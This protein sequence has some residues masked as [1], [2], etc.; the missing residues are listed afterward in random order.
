MAPLLPDLGR[1]QG[2]R[3]QVG[4]RNGAAGKKALALGQVALPALHIEH[5]VGQVLAASAPDLEVI[6][7]ASRHSEHIGDVD[8]VN[9]VTYLVQAP[10]E[11]GDLVH[12]CSLGDAAWDN[13]T[14]VGHLPA[15]Q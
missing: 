10:Q 4:G 9:E 5:A 12:S 13:P 7:V 15:E 3:L 1:V 8:G 2:G 6:A 14:V 11:R